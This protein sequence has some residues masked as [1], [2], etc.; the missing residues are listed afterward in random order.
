MICL[1]FAGPLP[2]MA[3]TTVQ[4]LTI[5][6]V[7]AIEGRSMYA[8]ILNREF[9]Y[10]V[11]R[12]SGL[13]IFLVLAYGI[14]NVFAL[15]YSLLLVGIIQLLTIWIIRSLVKGCAAYAPTAGLPTQEVE[16]AVEMAQPM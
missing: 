10:F 5:D 14:S 15:R 4:M 3:D 1:M 7:S 13:I 16:L 11:G 12:A 9:G 2:D 6:T 8:Y